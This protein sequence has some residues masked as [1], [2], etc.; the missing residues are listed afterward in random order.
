MLMLRRTLLAIGGV[1]IPG[2]ACAQGSTPPMMDAIEPDFREAIDSIAATNGI[3][4]LRDRPLPPGFRREIRAYFGWGLIH[5]QPAVRL[6][7]DADGAHGWFGFWWQGS[8]YEIPGVIEADYVKARQKKLASVRQ[9]RDFYAKLGC[10]AF[11][12]RPD[13]E[14]CTLPLRGVRWAEVLARLDSLGVARLPQQRERFGLDGFFMVVE[15]RD[16]AGHRSYSYWSPRDDAEDN[17]E[18]MA[19]AIMDVI[20]GL[21]CLSVPCLKALRRL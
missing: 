14:T 2:A 17:H 9:L 13:Y 11:R 8:D 21:Q 18:R 1:L 5:P 10:R 16:T 15:Y 4:S 19:A 6:W 3:A 7:E 12:A 20:T